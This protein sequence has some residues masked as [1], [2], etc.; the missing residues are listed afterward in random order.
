MTP[1]WQM[2]W[3][4]F[5]F[6][7]LIH[8]YLGILY[9]YAGLNILYFSFH[10]FFLRTETKEIEG[11]LKIGFQPVSCE[12]CILYGVFLKIVSILRILS[13][14]IILRIK[15]QNYI[16]KSMGFM[17][18]LFQYMLRYK[19]PKWGLNKLKNDFHV[20]FWNVSHPTSGA[21]YS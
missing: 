3:C 1:L 10:S 12:S 21:D 17:V 4:F 20:N 13:C 7:F 16:F 2:H 14:S 11:N 8:K 19:I 5:F 9:F 6:F 15:C 18:A